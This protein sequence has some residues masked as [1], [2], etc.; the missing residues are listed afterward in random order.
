MKRAGYIET[1]VGAALRDSFGMNSKSAAKLM[2][3]LGFEPVAIGNVLRN[4]FGK[5]KKEM[6]KVLNKELKYGKGQTKDIMQDMGYKKSDIKGAFKSVFGKV[7]G[8]F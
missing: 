4:T 7:K 1:D 2:K 3:S 5:N 8:L 6:V